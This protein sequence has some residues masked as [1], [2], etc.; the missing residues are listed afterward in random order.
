MEQFKGDKRT[1]EYRLWKE[2]QIVNQ[3]P[4]GLGDIVEKVTKATGIK[5]IT[6]AILGD[7]CGCDERKKRLN[8]N[9]SLGIAKYKVQRCL[10]EEQYIAYGDYIK[11][12]SLAFERDDIKMLTD[13]F[14]HVYAIQYDPR[15]FC[16]NCSGSAK[17]LFTIQTK[18]DNVH[19]DY[20]K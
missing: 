9:Y 20:E 7:D 14:A 15:N 8:V 6:E 3:E 1:K 13:L 5:A 10:T 2:S 12:R 17:T 19:R 11:R 16:T 18:L 4:K